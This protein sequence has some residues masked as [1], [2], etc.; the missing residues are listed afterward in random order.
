AVADATAYP[1]LTAVRHG[2]SPVMRTPGVSGRG[3]DV[4][5]EPFDDDMDVLT[6]RLADE[7]EGGGCA[8]VVRNTVKRVLE[9]AKALRARFGDGNVTVAHSCFVDVDRAAKDADLL[10]RFGPPGTAQGRPSGPH[11]V[12][13]SQVAEQSLD[14]DFDL[15]V[16]DL[17]P[18]DLLLQRMGRLHR[19]QRGADQQDRPER[20]RRARCLVTGADWDAEVP[21]PVR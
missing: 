5:L 9:T 20:L 1:V 10:T 8:L 12:V 3:P 11:I 21:V 4:V 6:E 19:H 14:V 15:L 2:A 13:A 17:C 7:L 18:V 16:T